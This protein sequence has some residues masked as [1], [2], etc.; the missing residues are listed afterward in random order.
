MKTILY[1]SIILLFFSCQKD[2]S[3]NTSSNNLSNEIYTIYFDDYEQQNNSSEIF[4]IQSDGTNEV[5]LTNRSNNNSLS[6]LSE[7]PFRYNDKIYFV[8]ENSTRSSR[9]YSMNLDGTNITAIQNNIISANKFNLEYPFVF[10]NGQKMVYYKFEFGAEIYTSN[11]DGTNPIRLTSYSADGNCSDPSVNTANNK[12]IYTNGTSQIYTM[13]I[14]G[15]AKTRITNSATLSFG[16][17]RF[18]PDGTKIIADGA[19]TLNRNVSSEIYI[20]N[21]DGTNLVKLTN[22]SKDGTIDDAICLTPIFSKNGAQIIYVSNQ[23]DTDYA[24]IFKMNLDGNNKKKITTSLFH[25]TNP[26]L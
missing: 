23:G 25:K 22:Y 1:F 19:Q 16:A 10:Q 20:M 12:I 21:N 26:N 3:N 5:K 15:T 17:P 18:S 14:D 9:F 7:Q 6:I 11:I 8:S 24:Q 2:N 13:N 4:K